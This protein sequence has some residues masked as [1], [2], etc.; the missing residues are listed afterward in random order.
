MSEKQFSYK[1]S[2]KLGVG[3]HL[4]RNVEGTERMVLVGTGTTR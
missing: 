3:E 4:E 2:Q 1:F